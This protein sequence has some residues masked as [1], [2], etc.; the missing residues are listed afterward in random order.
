MFLGR[1]ISLVLSID[2]CFYQ[3]LICLLLVLMSGFKKSLFDLN[4]DVYF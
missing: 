1:I 4:I 3:L 2:V